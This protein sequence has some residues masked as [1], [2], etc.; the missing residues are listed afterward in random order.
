MKWIMDILQNENKLN[1]FFYSKLY[2]LEIIN[3]I[4]NDEINIIK[5]FFYFNSTV[6]FFQ[7]KLVVILVLPN[8]FHTFREDNDTLK[9]S[10][11]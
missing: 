6:I 9:I 11:I 1:I 10:Q 5:L 4:F 8:Q 2:I 7:K 3:Y